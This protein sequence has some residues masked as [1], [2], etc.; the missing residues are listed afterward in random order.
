MKKFCI[1]G[2]LLLSLL[3]P[4]LQGEEFE[5]K[6]LADKN[7]L[8]EKFCTLGEKGDYFIS[9]GKYLILIG[10][11]SRTLYSILN[12][13]AADAMGSIIGFAPAGKHSV[14]NTII[15]SPYLRID[16]QRK[17]VPYTSVKPESDQKADGAL[18][19][20]ADAPFEGDNG[21]KAQITTTYRIIPRT[22]K[23]DVVS[24]IKNL[25]QSAIENLHYSIYFSANHIYSFSPFHGERH[26]DLNFRI[27]PKDGHFLGW[28]NR[29]PPISSDSPVPGT[30]EPG[31]SYDV[32]YILLAGPKGRQLL[33]DIYDFLD[34]STEPAVIYFEEGERDLTEVIVRD[35]LT[36][37]VFFRDFLDKP[38]AL[39]IPLPPGIYEVT[40]HFFPAIVEELF[41]VESGKKNSCIL[42]DPPHGIVNVKIQAAN[43]EHVPGKVTF[44][45]LD[46]TK[47]PYFEP[48]NPVKSGRNWET[49]KNSC[50]PE[51][52]GV[53]IRLPVGTY[54]VYASRG[55]EYTLESKI[56][57]IFQDKMEELTF[58]IAKVVKTDN[59]ISVDPHMHTIDS[60]GRVSIAERIRS[61]V[62]EGVEVA[63][64]TDHNYL[65]DYRPTLEGLGLNSYLATLVG[66]EVTT[67]GVIHFNSYP[68]RYREDEERNGAI[69]PHRKTASPLFQES[70]KKDPQALLQLNHPRSGTIGYFNNC[71]LDPELAAS[72]WNNLDLGFDVLEAL[73]GPY[74]YSS[75]EQ[76]IK[77]WFNLM[78]RGYYFPLVGS[79]DSHTIEGGQPGY[80]RT[81]VYYKGGRGDDL[82]SP[83][84]IQAMRKGHSFATNGPL[85]DFKINGTHIP[86]D[87]LTAQNGTVDIWLKV[88]SA[89]WIS[90]DEVRL[91][92]NGKR[93]ILFP[94]DNTENSVLKFSTTLTLP[95]EKDCSI[96]A[97]VMGNKSLFPVHQARA[98][99]GQQQNATLSYALTN[100][101]FIDVDGNGRFDPPL[102]KT[103]HL[104][105]APGAEDE[106]E[107]GNRKVTSE[108]Y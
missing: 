71:D 4:F 54:L 103:I 76:S 34:V 23:I 99:Y 62:A 30:L 32:S 20:R 22:G 68:L 60:D 43:G 95:L 106:S 8:P 42:Q 6:V 64:A 9:D 61:V 3:T 104:I 70:R 38:F 105:E 107:Y 26:P 86:G 90:V 35:V 92:I 91:I 94:V 47:S 37:T 5:I 101:I 67:G 31:Q 66:N 13:P 24:T 10:G 72:A 78:N 44:I 59:L 79:S 51:K 49:F 29:N 93:K 2:I 81:Y 25:G 84:L 41:L 75:N 55:P 88:E 17:D 1:I 98:R 19:I 14:G 48:E 97:E 96:A 21:E 56:L 50:Y 40:A 12:Y 53:E 11:T 100:P 27:Y 52:D 65:N 102:P 28:M 46:P 69:Y 58:H 7:D 108:N 85:I 36:R 16:G 33:E 73:N 39:E 45:G 57:E 80:S 77:D 74:F 63:I 15:G 82:D 18:V 89:P 87:S 83:T